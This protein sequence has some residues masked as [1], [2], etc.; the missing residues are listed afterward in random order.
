MSYVTKDTL[1]K[2]RKYIVASILKWSGPEG[3]IATLVLDYMI[4]KGWISVG[5]KLEV[6][7]KKAKYD[8]VVNDPNASADDIAHAWDDIFKH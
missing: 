1:K 2:L 7:Q 4:K 5:S 6:I 8:K 3:W